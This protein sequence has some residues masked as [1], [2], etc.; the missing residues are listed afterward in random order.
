MTTGKKKEA[1]EQGTVRDLLRLRMRNHRQD[2]GLGLIVPERKD[3]ETL[4]GFLV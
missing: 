3:Y 2:D 4:E 1:G